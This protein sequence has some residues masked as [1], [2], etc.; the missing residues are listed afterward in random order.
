MRSVTFVDKVE[1]EFEGNLLSNNVI[2]GDINNDGE[3]E[4][5]VGNVEGD[6]NIFKGD[7]VTAW[8]RCSGLGMI[9]CLGIGDLFNKMKNVVV[10]MNAEGWCN[11]FQFSSEDKKPV[12][13]VPCHTQHLAAN[14]K[15][16][17]IDDV[18][19]DGM[20]ELVIGHTDRVI[21]AY[22][23]MEYSDDNP[24]EQSKGILKLLQMWEPPGQI[25]SIALHHQNG[26]PK[27]VASQPGFCYVELKCTWAEEGNIQAYNE[28]SVLIVAHSISSVKA[29]NSIITT[30]ISGHLSQGTS[31]VDEPQCDKFVLSSLDGNLMM[32]QEDEMVWSYKLDH[33]LFSL[34]AL[35][36]T[37]DGKDEVLCCAWNG[38]TY[39]ADQEQNIAKFRFDGNV[40]AFCAGRYTIAG[41]TNP[42][43]VYATFDNKIYVYYNVKLPRIDSVNLLDL[44]PSTSEYLD[45][46][47]DHEIN[48]SDKETQ[49]NCIRK[50]LYGCDSISTT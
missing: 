5:V 30:E 40:A 49:A 22:K 19:G 7:A 42:C 6:L 37:G 44:L 41:A 34:T 13:M 26:I 11:I 38:M 14:T 33:Q 46:L 31:V 39:I 50:V 20:Y 43:L 18:D 17:L 25:G 10:T 45:L 48:Q 47:K 9:T 2:L 24:S 4:L 29:R 27:L 12:D 32:I 21:R 1:L 23:W 36:I 3:H 15:M 28:N 35:D 16:I 8:A